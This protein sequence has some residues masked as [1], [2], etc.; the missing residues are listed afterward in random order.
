MSINTTE[1]Q[2]FNE[3][4]ELCQRINDCAQLALIA[5]SLGR[6]RLDQLHRIVGHAAGRVQLTDDEQRA[7]DEAL[8]E[9]TMRF[10]ARDFDALATNQPF[11]VA[12]SQ[13]ASELDAQATRARGVLERHPEFAAS[14]DA[15]ARPLTAEDLQTLLAHYP[16]HGLL[17]LEPSEGGLLALYVDG[18]G[19][20]GLRGQVTHL[21]MDLTV[22]DEA[23]RALVRD[24]NL[25]VSAAKAFA[26]LPDFLPAATPGRLVVMPSPVL[27][28]LPLGL[29]GPAGGTLLD[30]FEAIVWMPNLSPLRARCIDRWPRAGVR[31]LVPGRN[32]SPELAAKTQFHDIA[33]SPVAGDATDEMA[34]DSGCDV[35]RDALQQTAVVRYYGHARHVQH[36]PAQPG[37]IPGP[38]LLLGRGDHMR[39]DQMLDVAFGLERVELWACESGIDIPPHPVFPWGADGFGFDYELLRGIRPATPG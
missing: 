39:V 14:D 17:R 21:P 18:R 1:V 37:R 24:G 35:V 15:V 2:Q 7:L 31:V 10:D 8:V 23:R 6:E 9:P 13:R 30:R 4:R 34:P 5:S 22:V 32:R 27:T 20:D 16:N 12:L 29:L 11:D 26:Q 19:P 28:V 25:P 33:M 36:D 3:W 38:Q